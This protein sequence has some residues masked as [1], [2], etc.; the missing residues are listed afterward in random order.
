MRPPLPLVA[1]LALVACSKSA[2]PP[3]K[4]PPPPAPT[5]SAAADA[6]TPAPAPA[7]VADAAA[8][9]PAPAADAAAP[10]PAPAEADASA[11]APAPAEADAAAPAP[12]PAPADA[13]VCMRTDMGIDDYS[14]TSL[15]GQVFSFCI[16]DDQ[17]GEASGFT[18][19]F[20]YDLAASTL[21]KEPPPPAPPA[22]GPEP[23]HA[24]DGDGWKVDLD[25]HTVSVCAGGDCKPLA[26]DGKVPTE[27]LPPSVSEDKTMI[28]V[29]LQE[30]GTAEEG[31][32]AWAYVYDVATRK[33]LAKKKLAEDSYIC[34]GASFVGNTVLV[35]MDVCAGPGG[36]AWLADPKK[37]TKIADLGPED[38]GRYA[39]Q[40][41]RVEGDRWAFLEQGGRSVVVQ[42]VV[43]GKVVSRLDLSE[44]FPLVEGARDVPAYG[45]DFEVLDGGG[46]LVALPGPGIG[47]LLV[48]DAK[49]AAVAKVHD[50]PRC[51][52]PK[53]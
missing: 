46:Y 37:L 7:P 24:L 33:R 26:L 30:G 12:A 47:R 49:L 4:T 32:T 38:F 17:A 48:L 53:P 40:W 28:V 50:L 2:P 11:P 41:Q 21:K 51:A 22:D 15:K 19:C 36:T 45:G 16:Y 3:E 5:P 14:L 25:A 43:S 9:A 52:A 34:G 1:A 20:A 6:S 31:G 13:A 8:P 35:A 29:T 18:S 42:D 44:Q 27:F 39:P 23:K 10:T